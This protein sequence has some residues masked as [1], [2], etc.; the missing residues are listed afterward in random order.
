MADFWARAASAA[1]R[2]RAL[3]KALK[4]DLVAGVKTIGEDVNAFLEECDSDEVAQTPVTSE[5]SGKSGKS[6]ERETPST[7]TIFDSSL[8]D[9]LNHSMKSLE[10]L[11]S[12]GVAAGGSSSQ[13]LPPPQKMM[14]PEGWRVHGD[15]T[16]TGGGV[17]AEEERTPLVSLEAEGGDGVEQQIQPVTGEEVEVESHEEEVEDEEEEDEGGNERL[18][19][20]EMSEA[21]VAEGKGEEDADD[22]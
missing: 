16:S 4:H 8:G 2:A 14:V 12:A 6:R 5:T 1:E 7:P 20:V 17:E 15:W 21:R 13:K 9:C 22:L 18:T 3:A 11:M 19:L 10:G